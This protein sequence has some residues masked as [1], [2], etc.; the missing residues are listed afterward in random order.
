MAEPEDLHKI[1]MGIVHGLMSQRELNKLGLAMARIIQKR[2]REGKDVEGKMFQPYS[3]RYKRRRVAQG[4]AVHPVDLTVDAVA[5][6]IAGITPTVDSSLTKVVLDIEGKQSG[7]R[8]RDTS[9]RFVKGGKSLSHR[10]LASYHDE[11][12][13]GKSKVVRHFWGIS[14]DDQKEYLIPLIEKDANEIL[15]DLTKEA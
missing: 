7:S 10:T 9:G 13:A 15:A 1:L 4:L 2:T 8:R 6:M 12:G 14:E 5:G 3:E 11:L